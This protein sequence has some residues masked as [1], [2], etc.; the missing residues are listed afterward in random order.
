MLTYSIFFGLLSIRWVH[1]DMENQYNLI[2]VIEGA[3]VFVL[4]LAGNL[5]YSF[6]FITSKIQKIWK[7]VFP[8]VILDF[9]LGVVI[10]SIYGKH[11]HNASSELKSIALI[12]LVATYSP[13]FL[14]HYKIGYGKE[15]DNDMPV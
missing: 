9:I 15:A 10:D 2:Y 7:F 3:C 6:D 4:I 5:I 8:I 13:T 1:N 14:A 12:L 11:A